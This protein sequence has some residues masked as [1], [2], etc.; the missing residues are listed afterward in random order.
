[1]YTSL[2]QKKKFHDVEFFTNKHSFESLK[3]TNCK[4]AFFAALSAYI[5]QQYVFNNTFHGFY[6]VE[7]H[8]CWKWNELRFTFS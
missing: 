1:M 7:D 8:V 5:G 3:I 4:R 2:Y 6:S